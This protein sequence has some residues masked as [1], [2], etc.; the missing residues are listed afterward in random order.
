MGIKATRGAVVSDIAQDGPA[1]KTGLRKE[2][3]I[4]GLNGKEVDGR[5]L[6]LAVVSMAPGS[7]VDLKVLRGSS[8]Q[9][10]SV[11][12]DAMPKDTQRADQDE[13]S[14]TPRRNRRG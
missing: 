6:R 11:T 7:T 8:E 2:D 12:L 4:I 3:V 14:Y 10:I 5:S 9:H 1:A 13:P